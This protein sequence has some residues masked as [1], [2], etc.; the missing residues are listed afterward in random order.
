MLLK[1]ITTTL[2]DNACFWPYSTLFTLSTCCGISQKP[3]Y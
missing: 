2:Y 1:L 3:I